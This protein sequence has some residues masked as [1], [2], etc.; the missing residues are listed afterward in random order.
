MKMR[1]RTQIVRVGEKNLFSAITVDG[2]KW[3][4]PKGDQR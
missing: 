4:F 3:E 2:E 1:L